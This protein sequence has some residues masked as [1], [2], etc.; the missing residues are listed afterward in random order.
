VL[1]IMGIMMLVTVVAFTDLGREAGMRAA[2][3]NARSSLSMAR[4]YAITH[5]AATTFEYGKTY[6]A[7]NTVRGY[8][9]VYT[10]VVY[11]SE[12]VVGDTNY[13]AEGI[14][15]TN[16][17]PERIQ[18]RFDGSCNPEVGAWGTGKFTRDIVIR[19]R[20]RKGI[21]VSSTTVVYRLTGRVESLTWGEQ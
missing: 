21:E 10:S 11:T 15:F 12:G 3:L 7:W 8:Y 13:L 1:A 5:R 18:F 19:E 9:L 16:D 4:Q 6:T 20:S 2:V 17:R 14:W